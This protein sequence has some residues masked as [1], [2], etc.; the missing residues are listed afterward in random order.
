MRI[1]RILAN[2]VLGDL[3]DVTYVII[4][5]IVVICLCIIPWTGLK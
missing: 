3:D 1:R 2:V 5:V 4:F